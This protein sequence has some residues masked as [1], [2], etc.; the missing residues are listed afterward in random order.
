MK[1]YKK[2]SEYTKPELFKLFLGIAAIILLFVYLNGLIAA[3]L[4]FLIFKATEKITYKTVD[5]E[6]IDTYLE[7]KKQEMDHGAFVKMVSQ[8]EA[9]SR[10]EIKM[11]KVRTSLTAKSRNKNIKKAEN[12]NEKL[13]DYL[14]KLK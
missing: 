10:S 7:K 12:V 11:S 13:K 1:H 6:D 14:S 8:L 3:A 5:I 2:F 9:E 4:T